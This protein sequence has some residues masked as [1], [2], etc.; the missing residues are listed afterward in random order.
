MLSENLK[1]T[2]KMKINGV[3][4]PN[5]DVISNQIAYVMQDDV[6]LGTFTPRGFIFNCFFDLF[7]KIHNRGFFFYC[8]YEASCFKGGKM[9]ESNKI[10]RN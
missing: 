10:T 3:N 7:I 4:V 9:E 8:F 5:I 6:L 2:G 1:I